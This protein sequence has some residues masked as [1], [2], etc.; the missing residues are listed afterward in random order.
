MTLARFVR[1]GRYAALIAFLA[2]CSFLLSV[3]KTGLAKVG[4]PVVIRPDRPNAITFD[5]VEACHVRL[6]IRAANQNQPCLD[7]VEIYGLDSDKNLALASEGAKPTASSCISG[8]TKHAIKN[9]NDGQYGN[10]FSW[11]S[12]GTGD[13][14]AQIQLPATTTIS[15]IVFSRDRAGQYMDRVPTDIEVQVSLDGTQ[16]QTVAHMTGRS[17]A[18]SSVGGEIDVPHIPAPPPPPLRDGA[19]TPVAPLSVV[20]NR[21]ATHDDADLPNLALEP[22]TIPL[23]SSTISGYAI[24]RLPHLNDGLSGNDHCWIAAAHPAWAQLDLGSEYW[25]Y[26]VA[27][28]NDSQGQYR[29]RA[30]TTFSILTATQYAEQSDAA[31]WH[32]VYHQ[33]N[34]TPLMDRRAFKF[35]PVRAR[36]VRI[37]INATN[38]DTVRLDEIEVYG[39]KQPIPLDKITVPAPSTALTCQPAFSEQSYEN[40]L[41]TAILA[42]EH[43]WLKTYGHADLS[44][45]LVPYNGRVKEYPR[46]A[47]TDVL[48]L[49]PLAEKP[50]LDGS[51]DDPCWQAA[52]R[53]VARVASPNDYAAGPLVET[54]VRAGI[55][56]DQLFLHVSAN[57]LLSSHVAVV[58][59][60]DGQYAGV[61]E[62]TP[63]G[64]VWNTYAAD[65]R[66]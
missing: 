1:G 52:S 32:T 59:R 17:V 34:G 65:G 39:Q 18:R 14:W 51:R 44:R 46:H 5:P 30:A 24:H 62:I 56:G 42:E 53:G 9:L 29:D 58:S 19:G 49:A 10:D 50:T 4:L 26:H 8:Y 15:K 7:E 31:T 38:S 64:L 23:A 63:E 33:E 35:Q 27:L 41:R 54:A 28:G 13:E 48:P 12:A 16:W 61:V 66:H 11:I 60:E 21:V 43:A 47:P 40:L 25:I 6:V 57:R 45:R 2:G 37:A 20:S 3:A 55:Y 22:T 36:W